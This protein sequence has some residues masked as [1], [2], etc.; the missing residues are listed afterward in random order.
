MISSLSKLGRSFEILWGGGEW[1]F[2]KKIFQLK[3]MFLKR[4]TGVFRW[5]GEKNPTGERTAAFWSKT[6]YCERIIYFHL[7]FF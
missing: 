4:Y 3:E 5:W 1:K 6:F 7:V 2:Q